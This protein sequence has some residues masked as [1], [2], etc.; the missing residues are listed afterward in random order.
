MSITAR[1]LSKRFGPK[2]VLDNVS[3]EAPSGSLVPCSG[4]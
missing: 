3:V 4:I 1:N 2:V